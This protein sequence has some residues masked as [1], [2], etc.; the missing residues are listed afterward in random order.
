MQ[1][2]PL[3]F[4]AVAFALGV[5]AAAQYA[6][7]VWGVAVA[8][9][10]AL[11]S[12]VWVKSAKGGTAF[13]MLMAAL[14][15]FC[16][17][18]RGTVALARAPQ[19]FPASAVLT[20]TVKRVRAR[21]DTRTEYILR[22]VFIDGRETGE[23]MVLT[24][25]ASPSAR[26]GD[27][28][29]AE[30][31]L[32]PVQNQPN[33]D[34]DAVRWRKTQGILT[35][36]QAASCEVTGVSGALYDAPLRLADTLKQV[37]RAQLDEQ[38]G[39]VIGMTLGDTQWLSDAELQAF[40]DSGVAHVLA[41]SGLHIGFVMA[42]ALWFCKR[43]RVKNRLALCGVL[44][45]LWT[46]CLIVGL[47]ASAVRACLMASILCIAQM[48]GLPYDLLTSIFASALIILCVA[49]LQ[50]FTAGFCLSFAAVLGIALWMGNWTAVLKRL[51][52][53]TALA[54]S[55]AVSLSAQ[56]G[57]LPVG[58]LFFARASN[59]AVLAS[60][61][62]VPLASVIM[63]GG[64]CAA[65]VGWAFMPLGLLVAKGVQGLA[66]CMQLIVAMV[67]RLPG[68]VVELPGIGVI[69]VLLWLC[70]MA[71][72]SPVCLWKTRTRWS[73]AAILLALCLVI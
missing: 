17:W 73:V 29:R 6:L 32:S 46:Y 34:F 70:A 66:V 54:D 42:V 44:A 27:Q 10:L 35:Q 19:D 72:T 38:A 23:T 2:R 50:L 68:A 55:L 56:M 43:L 63:I 59:Y 3:V 7:P 65:L 64:L 22:D 45:L 1:T 5:A 36:A 39:L 31:K 69:P 11:C 71:V 57:V 60:L 51:R 33:S 61:V 16:G 52:L 62:A 40:R 8:A 13:L 49:P 58:L 37:L 20:G 67:A 24:V 53:P 21:T 4:C 14:F 9:A 25:Y 18:M 41:V 28:V 12:I 48:L 47:P 30:A 26:P 15:F